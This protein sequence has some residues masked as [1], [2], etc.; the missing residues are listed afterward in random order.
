MYLLTTL[1][2]GII[3]CQLPGCRLPTDERA[4]MTPESGNLIPETGVRN[5]G[6]RIC[7]CKRRS[8][9]GII[10]CQLLD[11]RLTPEER[12]P[13]IIPA[14]E[15][16]SQQHPRTPE[17]GCGIS[18]KKL[19]VSSRS[20]WFSFLAHVAGQAGYAVAARRPAV[21]SRSARG[22][23]SGSAT[24]EVHPCGVALALFTSPTH[25]GSL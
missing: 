20:R 13:I 8:G 2:G 3:T 4:S 21:H 24:N 11:C 17:S 5:L 23:R 19:N 6:G 9:A 10:T 7:T 1:W 16:R 18:P 12:A 22:E 25:G 15:R 14:P